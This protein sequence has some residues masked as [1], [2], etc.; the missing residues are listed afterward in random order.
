MDEVLPD[1]GTDYPCTMRQLQS[2]RTVPAPT[3]DRPWSANKAARVLLEFLNAPV[4]LGSRADAALHRIGFALGLSDWGPDLI[5]KAF[6]DLDLAFFRGTLTG[7]T[8][9]NWATD[10][11]FDRPVRGTT[12]FLGHGRCHIRLN[13]SLIFCTGPTGTFSQM[14]TTVSGIHLYLAVRLK[15]C[16][17]IYLDMDLDGT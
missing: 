11:E 1:Y 6:R 16:E 5:I 17:L 4:P 2:Y 9:V 13:A 14:W 7:K 8:M 3:Y 12:R 15:L 10:Q